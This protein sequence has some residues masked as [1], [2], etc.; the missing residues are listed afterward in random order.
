MRSPLQLDPRVSW[1]VY[2]IFAVLFATGIVWIVADRLKDPEGGEFWQGIATNMLMIYGGA[3]MIALVVIGA[4][5]PNH[6]ARAW[7]ARRNRIAGVGML[8]INLVLVITAFALYYLGSETLRPWISDIHI[9]FG[10]SIPAA[11]VVHIFTGRQSR[12]R[13]HENT[14]PAGGAPDLS[15][16][17]SV[18]R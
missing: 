14:K 5:L 4:L 3:A 15:N 1:G 18:A 13:A 9:A 8:A 16:S 12:G 6:V 17:G 2:S 7:R 11:F 10:I